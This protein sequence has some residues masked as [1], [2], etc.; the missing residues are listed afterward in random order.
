MEGSSDEALDALK[1]AFGNDIA[2]RETI[3]GKKVSHVNPYFFK[4][5]E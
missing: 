3:G 5:V 4:V 2:I 1:G